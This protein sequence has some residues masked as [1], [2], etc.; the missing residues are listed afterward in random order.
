M[1]S[2]KQVE[3]YGHCDKC[4]HHTSDDVYSETCDECLDEPVREG[5]CKPLNFEEAE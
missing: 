3:F 1:D 5:T 4:K 2:A